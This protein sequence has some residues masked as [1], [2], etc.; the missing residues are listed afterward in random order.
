MNENLFT[1]LEVNIPNINTICVISVLL[2]KDTKT[3]IL[4]KANGYGH[5]TGEFSLILEEWE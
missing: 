2:K 5:G 4:V 1:H 3:L